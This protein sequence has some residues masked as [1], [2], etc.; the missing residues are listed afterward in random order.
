LVEVASALAVRA[1]WEPDEEAGA[2]R[3][4]KEWHGGNS[5]RVQDRRDARH[6]Q[7]DLP[8][9]LDLKSTISTPFPSTPR[10]TLLS[11]LTEC[12]PPPPLENVVVSAAAVVVTVV[13]P[14]V[15]PVAVPARTRSKSG[16]SP[17]L[18][19]VYTLVSLRSSL[20][21]VPVTKLGR[22]VKDGKIK[23][24]EEIYL[25]SLPVKEYQIIDILLPK[26]K[27]SSRSPWFGRRKEGDE[28]GRET[29]A[30][31]LPSQTRS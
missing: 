20:L 24:I 10:L 9:L 17:L 12:L 5:R 3:V 18:C 14:V 21:R 15:V 31:F 1:L 16:T 7:I 27:G 26:L 13:D 28:Y 30:R 2:L 4:V 22:L 11:H 6:P 25:F 8:S 19:L 29:D 23:S